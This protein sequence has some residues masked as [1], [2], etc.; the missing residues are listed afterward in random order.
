MICTGNSERQL[1][2][3]VDA[4]EETARKKHRLKPPRVEGHAVSG[5]VLVDFGSVIVHAFSSEQRKR[6]K[7]EELWRDGKM[8]VRIQ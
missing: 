2:A 4:L 1:S 8:I 6:Y 5:W 7:L 3:L